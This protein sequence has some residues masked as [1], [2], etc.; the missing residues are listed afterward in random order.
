MLE[1][2]RDSYAT[3]AWLDAYTSLLDADRSAPLAAADLELLATSAYMLGRDDDVLRALE[4]AHQAYLEGGE[5]L[6]GV[7][8]AFWLGIN[9]VM[10]E[11]M[12]RATGWFA[13]AHRLLEGEERECV[14]RGYLLLPALLQHAA[15]GDDA[16]AYATGAD[17]VAIGKKFGDADLVALALHEQGHALVRQGRVQ[18]GLAL[19]DEAMVAV[20]AGEL[21]PVV[22]G[23]IYCSVIDGCQQVYELGRAREW[24]TALTRWCE[25]QPDMVAHTGLCLIHRAEIMQLHGSWSDALEEARRAGKR[26]ALRAGQKADAGH[27]A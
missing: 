16:A 22:T 21:S 2:G 6:P 5:V 20:T 14:E 10:Q 18:Q 25:E 8:C 17:A 7:R 9:L 1:R 27:A 12:S 23:L 3:W 13:R 15:A 19:L 26:F 24:T 11:Q 4:R